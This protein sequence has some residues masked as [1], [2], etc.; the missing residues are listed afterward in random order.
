[1][2]GAT[3]AWK[4]TKGGFELTH[5]GG[6]TRSES[7]VTRQRELAADPAHATFDLRDGNEPAYAQIAKQQ[8]QRWLAGQL[9]RRF[10]VPSNPGDIDVGNEIVSVGTLE[11]DHLH[12]VIC[13]SL[14]N[15]RYQVAN[16]FRP[17]QIDRRSRNLSEEDSSFFAYVQSLENQLTCSA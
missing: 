5:D 12:I 14:L 9:R 16:E 6:L 13:L 1:M 7:H 17:Q 15:E 10:P 11:D 2:L 3:G 8:A 4:D